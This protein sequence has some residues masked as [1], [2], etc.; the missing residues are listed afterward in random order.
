[1]HERI[2]VSEV[3]FLSTR[4]VGRSSFAAPRWPPGVGRDKI[5][6][7]SIRRGPHPVAVAT[8]GGLVGPAGV[9]ARASMLA[10]FV[11]CLLCRVQR[12]VPAAGPLP[13]PSLLR[14]PS[15]TSSSANYSSPQLLPGAR[16]APQ[17]AAPQTME[18]QRTAPV[19]PYPSLSPAAAPVHQADAAHASCVAA[20]FGTAERCSAVTA[21][22][23]ATVSAAG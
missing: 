13:S 12:T 1:M 7:E 17:I 21:Q 15:A 3:L 6:R 4:N 2:D 9:R 14:K 19:I 8:R 16:S 18:I 5:T 10:N 22:R 20:A 23:S 11:L